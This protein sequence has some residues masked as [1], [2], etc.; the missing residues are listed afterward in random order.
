MKTKIFMNTFMVFIAIL[1]LYSDTFGQST[2][3]LKYNFNLQIGGQRKR[4]V[5]S[6]TSLRAVAN[7]KL[8][9]KKL[10]INNLSTYTYT[11]AN[12]FNIADDWHFRTIAT[13]K[14]NSTTRF[15]P[16]FGH[17][18]L[19]NV[20]YRIKNSH[21]GLAGVKI[22]PVKNYKNFSFIF[23]AGYEFSQYT[24]EVF[25][26]SPLVSSQRDFAL[27]FFNLS[28]KHQLGK[29]KIR[30]EY[31]LSYVQSVKEAQDFS[32]WLTSGVSVPVGKHLFLGV[33]YDFRFRNVHL[34]DIPNI[35]DLLMFNLRFNIAN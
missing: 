10:V 33:N 5:F 23:G 21:R 11:E 29:S 31:N 19:Q 7:T 17:N 12:G 4:G 16:V 32:F 9:N 34:I 13:L 26:K 2:D 25:Q 27:G 18:Y 22:L 6:Q 35:N 14:L 24:D 3:T 30:L 1:L 20:L 8:E 15:S 28:G